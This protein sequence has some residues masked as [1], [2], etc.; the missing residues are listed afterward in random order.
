[1]GGDESRELILQTIQRLREEDYVFTV[2]AHGTPW[3]VY[4]FTLHGRRGTLALRLVQQTPEIGVFRAGEL[5]ESEVLDQ[6]Q[7][8]G[9]N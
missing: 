9:P 7:K 5:T 1:M 3:D 6:L 8:D 4:R 2:T